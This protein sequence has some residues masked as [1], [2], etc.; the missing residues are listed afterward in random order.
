MSLLLVPGRFKC[1]EVGVEMGVSRHKRRKRCREKRKDPVE[2]EK[3]P[4]SGQPSGTELVISC[5]SVHRV[6][7]E[8]QRGRG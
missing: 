8:G 6:E 7:D 5:R 1:G 3:D 4:E 2:V